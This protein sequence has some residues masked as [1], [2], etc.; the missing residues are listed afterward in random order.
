LDEVFE[1]CDAVTVLR[2]GAVVT[3]GTPAQ[4]PKNEIVAAMAGPESQDVAA[5]TAR[6]FGDERLRAD[7]I[8]GPGFHD[9]SLSVRAG[10]I[11][12]LCGTGASGK[13]SMAE[14]IAGLR[15]LR[16]GE[17]Y[18]SGRIGAVPR[19]R[20]REGLV[21]NLSVAENATMTI[22]SRL[23]RFGFISNS[24]RERLARES[25]ERFGIVARPDQTV[26]ELS[27]GNQQKVVL[28]RALAC[29][30]DVLI[31]I[32]PTAGVDVH[33]KA[34]LHACIARAAQSGSAVLLVSDDLDELRLCDRVL[35]MLRGRIS[36]EATAGWTDRTLIGAM[37]GVDCA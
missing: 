28:A 7:S 25:I 22:P 32:E 33:S 6:E 4:M 10:E 29:E 34:Q 2:D 1:V 16:G 3:S 37:E 13:V 27:G 9:V 15:K 23:G 35:V 19:D 21:L 17:V 31:L 18:A 8:C 14:A 24:R 26:S 11:V 30:P 36:Y 12:G 5:R 20:H